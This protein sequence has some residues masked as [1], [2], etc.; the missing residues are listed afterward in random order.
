MVRIRRSDFFI[1]CAIVVE[2]LAFMDALT[3]GG[4]PEVLKIIAFEGAFENLFRIIVEEG[5]IKGGIIV[6]DCLQI[7]LNM[8]LGNQSNQVHIRFPFFFPVL[9]TTV[10]QKYFREIG[11]IKYLLPL[12]QIPI[13]HTQ[14]PK[15]DGLLDNILGQNIKPTQGMIQILHR[16]LIIINELVKPTAD[17]PSATREIML[18]TRILESIILL[19]LS[20]DPIKIVPEQIRSLALHIVGWIIFNHKKSQEFLQSYSITFQNNVLES[21]VVHICKTVLFDENELKRQINEDVFK[22]E[23]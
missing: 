2:G 16:T 22:K 20:E 15:Q 13:P 21:A 12:L 3:S 10:S 18:N 19:A 6:Q 9:T 23:F 7:V 4:N 11:Y 17:N 8:I 14:N 1:E 5:G